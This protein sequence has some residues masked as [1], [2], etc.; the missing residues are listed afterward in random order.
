MPVALERK[1]KRQVAGKKISKERKDA[2]VYGTLRKTGWK[3]KRELSALLDD[4][5][6]FK[7]KFDPNSPPPVGPAVAGLAAPIAVQ[8]G[9]ALGT[10]GAIT[11][12]KEPA[13]AKK[14]MP[15]MH[16]INIEAQKQGA[17]VVKSPERLA[18]AFAVRPGGGKGGAAEQQRNLVKSL[19]GK[20]RPNLVAIHP[21]V[22]QYFK[23][24]ILAHEVGHIQQARWMTQPWTR[25]LGKWGP[26]GGTAIAAGTGD[27]KTAGLS[28]LAGTAGAIPML[29]SEVDASIRGGKLLAK[30]GVKGVRRLTSGIGLATYGAMAA[31]PGIAYGTKKALGGY[32][33][34]KELS[35]LFDNLLNFEQRKH[36][37]IL[38]RPPSRRD[39]EER[40]RDRLAI[41]SSLTKTA[42][43]AGVLGASIYGAHEL[44]KHGKGLIKGAKGSF[45]SM[46]RAGQSIQDLDKKTDQLT[47][48][49]HEAVQELKTY[50]GSPEG[51]AERKG[52]SRVRK[53][54][55]FLGGKTKTPPVIHPSLLARLSTRMDNL[56]EFGADIVDPEMAAKLFKGGA[57][58]KLR[59]KLASGI[60]TAGS[61]ALS[62]PASMAGGLATGSG[63]A[64]GLP[65][66]KA[67]SDFVKARS[68][69]NAALPA[70]VAGPTGMATGA[71]ALKSPVLQKAEQ[72]SGV[73]TSAGAQQVADQA[74]QAASQPAAQ[75]WWKRNSGAL[76][77]GGVGAGAGLGA[78][79]AIRGGNNRQN[80][81]AKLDRLIQF[82]DPRPR[83]KLGEFTG[84]SE[85]GP[86]PNAMV[87]TYRQP[88][89]AAVAGTSALVGASGTA[90]GLAV[91]YGAD[92]LKKRLRKVRV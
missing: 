38:Q 67:L 88:G 72:T 1:L 80:Y 18:P 13:I 16:Q 10:L 81:I 32:Q 37:V 84:Q 42:A 36:V 40:L 46:S 7:E 65:V 15:L 90:G 48:D 68:G 71:P 30:H 50:T 26:L 83:N 14:D 35:S 47:K 41:L 82:Q 20:N 54:M 62:S 4:L 28:A 70:P 64:E 19:G 85:G 66:N 5:L 24:G 87:K 23:P 75:P 58:D 55:K 57:L 73:T 12:G 63:G 3:P 92:Q 91:K 17:Y 45:E 86:D 6:E 69:A 56:I 44:H 61:G 89:L 51:M 79:L 9:V 74:G 78:G 21:S 25:H 22:R 29:T 52:L 76:V 33:A 2:Y 27:E 8:T 31:M 34:K 49:V 53:V 39:P 11:T 77:A 59:N 60:Q 43:G